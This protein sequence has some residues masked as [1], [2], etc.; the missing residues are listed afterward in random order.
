[1]EEPPSL[2]VKINGSGFNHDS[3][4]WYDGRR[5]RI[6]RCSAARRLRPACRAVCQPLRCQLVATAGPSKS[7]IR[8]P[9]ITSSRRK[10]TLPQHTAPVSHETRCGRSRRSCMRQPQHGERVRRQRCNKRCVRAHDATVLRQCRCSR[11]VFLC[12]PHAP[13]FESDN[14]LDTDDLLRLDSASS[15][16]SIFDHVCGH[17]G[18]VSGTFPPDALQSRFTYTFV[19]L[20]SVNTRASRQC[21]C[22]CTGHGPASSKPLIALYTQC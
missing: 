15:G 22:C 3:V 17:R 13:S 4:T 8:T 21:N 6:P 7:A 12:M 2:L 20:H 19:C 14:V 16:R 1:M 10:S 9:A 11:C 5:S 18:K